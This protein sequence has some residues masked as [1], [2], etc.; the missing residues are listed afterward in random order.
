M[1]FKPSR[2]FSYKFAEFT[3]ELRVRH[4]F[5]RTLGGSCF[6]QAQLFET[7]AFYTVTLFYGT[8]PIW[9]FFDVDFQRPAS[10]STGPVSI[11]M[12]AGWCRTLSTKS[13]ALDEVLQFIRA[14]LVRTQNPGNPV[15][16][17]TGTGG[18]GLLLYGLLYVLGLYPRLKA[19]AAGLLGTSLAAKVSGLAPLFFA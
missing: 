3:I 7:A 14:L 5:T 17:L 2:R 10:S 1:A 15:E 9:V 18:C 16:L 6:E 12:D 11:E 19:S 4:T 8:F 13:R